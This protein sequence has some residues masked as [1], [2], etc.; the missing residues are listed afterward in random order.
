MGDD[1]RRPT[2]TP[3]GLSPSMVPLSN[4]LRLDADFLTPP[5]DDSRTKNNPTTPHTQPLSGITRA[6]FS[7]IRFRSPL[8][9]ESLLFS[10]PTG[11]EMFHFPAFPP[12][13]L[14]IQVQ[15]TGHNSSQVSPFGH[16]RINA[17]LPTPQ[18]LSQAPTSFIGSRCQGIHRVPFE[19]CHS[20]ILNKNNKDTL[21]YK[22]TTPHTTTHQHTPDHQE[23]RSQQPPAPATSARQMLASTIQIS[24]TEETTR[25]PAHQGRDAKKLPDTPPPPHQPGPA[26]TGTDPTPAQR[27]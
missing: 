18:G 2:R 19:A 4:G 21:T 7:L 22:I 12:H 15:V 20:Q 14:Y 16:P 10:L 5:H 8:L 27:A 26:P 25:D 11:T 24:N 6:R 13:T 1:Q 23:T 17:R 9:S 3:T